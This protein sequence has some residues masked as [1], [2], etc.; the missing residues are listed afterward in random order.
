MPAGSRFGSNAA[1]SSSSIPGDVKIGLQASDHSGWI[2]L[3][4]RAKNTF[5]TP[6]QTALTSLGVGA[7]I[8]DM[9]DRT[10][11]GVSATKALL[12]VGGFNVIAQ[13]QL[14]NVAPAINDPG[15]RHTVNGGQNWVA[16]NSTFRDGGTNGGGLNWNYT[17]DL[18]TTGITSGSINGN[19]TQQTIDP[20]HIAMNFFMF[21]GS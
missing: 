8:P 14:P 7:N 15:H 12:S 19:V 6:Q 1:S 13:N 18:A 2:K 10:P 9:R 11:M 21:A 3:D 17:M 16:G 4:G 20:K 5:T